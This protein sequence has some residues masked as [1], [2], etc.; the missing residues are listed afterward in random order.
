MQICKQMKINIFEN[1]LYYSCIINNLVRKINYFVTITNV[2]KKARQIRLNL[3][4]AND[5][6]NL[7]TNIFL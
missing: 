2:S 1:S 6:F 7:K 5:L 4:V 3:I